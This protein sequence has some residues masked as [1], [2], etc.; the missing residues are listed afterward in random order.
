MFWIGA[1]NI[2][3]KYLY[4]LVFTG[5]VD[6]CHYIHFTWSILLNTVDAH[7]FTISLTSVSLE[8][9]FQCTYVT[10]VPMYCVHVTCIY[11]AWCWILSAIKLL[12]MFYWFVLYSRNEK[13][14]YN[15]IMGDFQ[16]R[17]LTQDRV[18]KNL[19][20]YIYFDLNTLTFICVHIMFNVKH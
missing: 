15:N 1:L 17:F 16:L 14:K 20:R 12:S 7:A 4:S 18:F 9:C 5:T 11:I 19:Y 3:T 2:T 6:P 10:S 8:A 13:R